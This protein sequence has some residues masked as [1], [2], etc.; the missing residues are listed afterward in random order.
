MIERRTCIHS[1]VNVE[2]W[3]RWVVRKQELMMGVECLFIL[4]SLSSEECDSMEFADS[5]SMK[6]LL[7]CSE[8]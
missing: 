6:L 5:L 1:D 7:L 8:K 2:S 3:E 4:E